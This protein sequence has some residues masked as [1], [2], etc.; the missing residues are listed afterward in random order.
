MKCQCSCNCSAEFEPIDREKLLNTIQ[1][2]RLDKKQIEFAMKRL[3]SIICE[4]C[5]VGKHRTSFSDLV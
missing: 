2:G 5:F 1:H 4:T 3:D